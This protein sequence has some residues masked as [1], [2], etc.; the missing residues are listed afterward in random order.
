MLVGEIVVRTAV[1]FVGAVVVVVDVGV[2]AGAG[3]WQADAT[4]KAPTK[5]ARVR[6]VKALPELSDSVVRR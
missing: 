3:A 1:V 5:I 4:T 6:C 2:G